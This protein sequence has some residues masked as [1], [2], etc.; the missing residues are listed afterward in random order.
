M[1]EPVR[2]DAA[3]DEES[4]GADEPPKDS[5]RRFR[6]VFE[7]PNCFYSVA[8]PYGEDN[9]HYVAVFT[10]TPEPVFV[11]LTDLRQEIGGAAIHV[12]IVG[13]VEASGPD[14]QSAILLAAQRLEAVLWIG[15]LQSNAAVGVPKLK[16]AIELTPGAKTT[17]A[18]QVEDNYDEVFSKKRRLD[19]PMNEQIGRHIHLRGTSRIFRALHWY[20][21]GL[22][23]E[24][25]IDQFMG[26][27]VGLEALN[28]PLKDLLGGD[29]EARRCPKCGE[30][31]ET[32][33][34]NGVRTLFRDHNPDGLKDYKLCRNLRR[35][36][37]HSTADL[38][39]VLQQAPAA[40]EAARR[41]LRTA[42]YLLLGLPAADGFA[43]PSTIYNNQGL[44]AEYRIRYSTPPD[45]FTVPPVLD[46]SESTIEVEQD[47]E[48]RTVRWTPRVKWDMNVTVEEMGLF[49][50]TPGGTWTSVPTAG[51]GSESQTVDDDKDKDDDDQ[52]E[53]KTDQ[54]VQ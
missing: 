35:D 28:P 4:L 39:Q 31:A 49:A 42:I 45:K 30:L 5:M 53:D 26:F 25:P 41:M 32:P 27:W 40:A 33:T 17:E 48:R 29:P 11:S 1:S 8:P 47:G 12:G 22:N 2:S 10:D 9:G 37:Q 51:S 3:K 50:R 21:K 7:V 52:G 34:V 18:V 38:D 14:M 23:E 46:T 6:V 36:I 20:R 54:Q 15:A 24:D 43:A 13:D 44:R 16:F 19:L